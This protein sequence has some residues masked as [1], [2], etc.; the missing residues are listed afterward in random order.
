MMTTG[1]RMQKS[2]TRVE[3]LLSQMTVEEKIGQLRMV[4]SPPLALDAGG[5]KVIDDVRNGRTGNFSYTGTFEEKCM[6]QKVA[7]EESR[8]GIP[9]TFGKDILNGHKTIFPCNLGQAASWDLAA[10]EQGERTAASEAT[11]DGISWTF[12]PNVDVSNDPRWGRI[13]EGA[14]EDPYLGSLI[15]AAR[16]RGFQGTDLSMRA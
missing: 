16:V 6:L 7:V 11:A 2:S 5:D 10:I 8:L 14:G 15:A 12:S 4:C 13:M 1:N 3:S 9:L